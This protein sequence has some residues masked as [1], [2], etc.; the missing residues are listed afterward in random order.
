MSVNSPCTTVGMVNYW[1]LLKR[2]AIRCVLLIFL[3]SVKSLKELMIFLSSA[4]CKV[5][6]NKKK[7]EL[8]LSRFDLIRENI[9]ALEF[10]DHHYPWWSKLL[11]K[12]MNPF[13]L[14]TPTLIPL[15]RKMYDLS[16]K[17]ASTDYYLIFHDYN[18]SL[19]RKITRHSF[20]ENIFISPLKQYFSPLFW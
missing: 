3:Q 1:V 8:V 9:F 4:T 12:I 19:K 7:L 5:N 17:M 16:R 14:W 6:E 11:R 15:Q 20:L 10:Y 18:M 2:I 13:T